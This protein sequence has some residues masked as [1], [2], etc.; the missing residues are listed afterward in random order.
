MFRSLTKSKIGIVLAIL[1]A[2]SMFFFRGGKRYSNFF[3]SDNIVAEV[4]GTPIST[5]KFRRSLQININQFNQMLGKQISNE[6]IVSYQIHNLALGA[7]INNAVFENEYNENNYILDDSVIAKITK[8]RIPKLYNNENKIDETTLNNFLSQQGLTIDDLV[9]MIEVET[10]S[11]VFDK[12]FFNVNLPKKINEKI[13]LQDSQKREIEYVKFD[14]NKIQEENI[15]QN[16]TNDQIIEYYNQNINNYKSEET[17]DISFII[18]DK[19]QYRDIFEPSQSRINEYYNDNKK[20][21]L[22]S[23]KRDFIQFNFKSENEAE[24]FLQKINNKEKNEILKFATENN[25]LFN[26][27]KNLSNYEVLDELSNEIF[28]LEIDEISSIIKTTLAYHIV[29]LKNIIPAKEKL[30]EEVSKEIK[31]TLM[32]LEL[33]SYIN[34]LKSKL[35]EEILNGA[36]LNE[37]SQNNDLKIDKLKNIKINDKFGSDQVIKNEIIKLAF[38]SNKDFVSDIVDFAQKSFIFNVDDVYASVPLK[39]S[40]VEERVK[41][42]WIINEKKKFIDEELINNFENNN[43]IKE[44]SSSYYLNIINDKIDKKNSE[45][46]SN[47]IKKIF[48]YKLHENFLHYENENVYIGKINNI[49]IPTKIENNENK[50]NIS[51]NLKNAFGDS[52]IKNKKISTNDSLINAIVSQY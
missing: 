39:Y 35:S 14:I 44:F 15:V 19:N 25:I 51:S 47:F 6:E 12:L 18:I 40:E 23:E 28:N 36:N 46:P 29:I 7:L 17:R 52:I 2:I 27:F 10:K 50:I 38:K 21:F 24:V 32:S 48:D 20:F 33:N 42:D 9:N 45:L 3:D 16:G 34:E 13:Y 11:D 43:F 8:K 37:I 31:E 5:T 49:I 1:F 30:F 22:E 4:N 41:S 26:D